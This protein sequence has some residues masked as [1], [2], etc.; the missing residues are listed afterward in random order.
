MARRF[1][2]I[3]KLPSGR[4]RARYVGPDGNRHKAPSTFFTRDDAATWLRS[5]QKRIEFDEWTPPEARNPATKQPTLTVGEFL[6]DWLARRAHGAGALKPSTLQDYQATLDRCILKIDGK[7]GKLRSIT[8][9][10]L[11]RKDIL[12]WWDALTMQH[13]RPNDCAK[14]YKRLHTAMNDAVDRELTDTNPVRINPKARVVTHKRKELPTA[15]QLQAIVDQLDH[16]QPRVDGRHKLIAILT[17]FHG[18]RIGEA[19]S[20]RRKDFERT[21]D[22]GW[23]VHIRTNVYRKPGH[24]MIRMDSTKTTA[25]TRTVPVFARFNEDVTW[26]LD[27]IVGNHPDADAFPTPTGEIIM[28]TSHRSVLNRA[29]ERAGLGDVVIT[30]HYGRVWLITVLAEQGMPIPAIG[31]LLGQRDLKTITEIYMRATESR[32][33]SVLDDVNRRLG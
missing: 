30:P 15:Q 14:A 24:G 33:Q 25:G 19:L 4:Y 8:L 2:E 26:H 7:A 17:L 28:D 18:L 20:L 10:T 23:V 29:K 22:G 5:E 6:T 32:K 9:A 11:D 16:T 1:G 31:E 27:H 3:S 13:P 12:A 21:P